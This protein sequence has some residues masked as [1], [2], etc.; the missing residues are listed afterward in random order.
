MQWFLVSIFQGLLPSAQLGQAAVG[1]QK[2]TLEVRT[3]GHIHLLQF[4]FLMASHVK[5]NDFHSSL[6]LFTQELQSTFS[7]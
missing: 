1:T 2:V 3:H 6:A 5:C 7:K 4:R